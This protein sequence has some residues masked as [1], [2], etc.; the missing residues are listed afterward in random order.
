LQLDAQ[1]L[2]QMVPVS[3]VLQLQALLQQASL[4]E[5]LAS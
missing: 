5:R 3:Q 2:E 4:P 1:A